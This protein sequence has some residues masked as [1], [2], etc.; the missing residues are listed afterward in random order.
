[1]FFF[2][3]YCS[4]IVVLSFLAVFLFVAL[5]LFSNFIVITSSSTWLPK[6][7]FLI[8]LGV[9]AIG[10]LLAKLALRIPTFAS[11]VV[12][13][14]MTVTA[15]SIV[16]VLVRV[17]VATVAVVSIVV[18]AVVDMAADSAQQSGIHGQGGGNAKQGGTSVRQD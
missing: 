12:S 17:L 13:I 9:V 18:Q 7:R 16:V 14:A 1:V 2:V 5:H 8:S 3:S 4:C 15:A 6:I 10:R 11:M